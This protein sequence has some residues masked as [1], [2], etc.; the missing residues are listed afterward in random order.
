[1]LEALDVH[2]WTNHRYLIAGDDSWIMYNQTPPRMWALDR[3][4]VHAI[5]R[6]C[7]Q[8]RKTM[9]TAFSGVSGFGLVKIL[10]EGTKRSSGY[11][12]DEVLRQIDE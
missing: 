5:V 1:M 11:F 2:A 10:T 8:S 6:L 3:N 4:H 12:K 9:A 7:H